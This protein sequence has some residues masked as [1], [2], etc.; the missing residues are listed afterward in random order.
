MC[1]FVCTCPVGVWV[2][3]KCLC[4]LCGHI[5]CLYGVVLICIVNGCVFV[6]DKFRFFVVDVVIWWLV[7]YCSIDVCACWKPMCS[8]LKYWF[9]V[10]TYFDL[11]CQ[12]SCCLIGCFPNWTVDLLPIVFSLLTC[13]DECCVVV[14]MARCSLWKPWLKLMH[15]F[16][17][18]CWFACCVTCRCF[19]LLKSC[20]FSADGRF[21]LSCSSLQVC[22][23]KVMDFSDEVLT[24]STDV[25]CLVRLMCVLFVKA[26]MFS[27]LNYWLCLLLCVG[28]SC[29]MLLALLQV[30]SVIFSDETCLCV[31]SITVYLRMCSTCYVDVCVLS[32]FLYCQC[33]YVEFPW[34]F[35]LSRV[36][37]ACVLLA[38]ACV[39]C[40]HMFTCMLNCF[41]L[42]RWLVLWVYVD[43]DLCLL[44]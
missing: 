8:L 15:R 43:C 13:Y 7:V 35:V 37:V 3:L 26:Y 25:F 38:H 18:L 20:L 42:S 10:L 34:R 1:C 23:W 30:R 31:M 32:T 14:E 6:C 36:C 17:L 27:V 16:E 28:L 22:C 21:K 11:W 24:L 39:P 9:S 4:V 41:V 19:S 33:L 40:W 5:V 44:M 12:C 29:S 2:L